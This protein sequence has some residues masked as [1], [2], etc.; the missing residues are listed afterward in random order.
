MS[1]KNPSVK[2]RFFICWMAMFV[3]A[4]ISG[5]AAA[6]SADSLID[7]LVKKGVLTEQEAADLR[8]DADRDFA[9]AIQSKSGMPDWVTSFVWSGDF[10]VRLDTSHNTDEPDSNSSRERTRYVYR[11]RYGALVKIK[12]DFEVGIRFGTGVAGQ[13]LSMNQTFGNNAEKKSLFLDM[14]YLKWHLANGPVFG[15]N[16]SVGKMENP[17]TQKYLKF[18]DSVFDTNYTPEGIAGEVRFKLNPNHTFAF[19]AGAFIVDEN[20]ASSDDARLLVYNTKLH[21]T[22]SPKFSTVFGAGGYLLQNS[23]SITDNDNTHGFVGSGNTSA[24]MNHRPVVLDG[25]ITYLLD[26][27]PMYKG[28]FPI[29]LTGEYIKN[30]AADSLNEGSAVGI[31]LGKAGKK[32]LWDFS[33]RFKQIGANAVWDDLSDLDYGAWSG[34]A[35]SRTYAGGTD[36]RGHVFLFLYNLTD[37]CNLSVKYYWTERISSSPSLDSHRAQIDLMWKF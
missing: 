25:T 23:G 34:S 37:A 18:S 19:G 16:L 35:G 4:A 33:W 11:L 2:S 20:S 7:K 21:S 28:A 27:F 22:W 24:T 10:R 3:T 31:Q 15:L 14:A 36:I 13:P 29:S 26:S 6:Q 12:D 5:V 9:T 1:H 32:G 30:P 17:F 8:K